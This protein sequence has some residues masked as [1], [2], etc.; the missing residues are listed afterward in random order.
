MHVPFEVNLARRLLKVN[1]LTPAVEVM[2]LIRKYADVEISYIPLDVDAVCLNLKRRGMRPSVIINSGRGHKRLRFTVAHELGHVLIP[3]HRGSIVDDVSGNES[4]NSEYFQIE[5]EAN[6]FAS[7]LLMPQ[8]WVQDRVRLIQSPVA[9]VSEVSDAADVSIQAAVF[10]TL[11]LLPKGFVFAE[12]NNDSCVVRSGRSPGTIA[13]APER[14]DIVDPGAE[15]PYAEARWPLATSGGFY[16]WWKL[17]SAIVP[18]LKVTS[19]WR[20][21]LNEILQDLGFQDASLKKAYSSVSAT[22]AN[23]NGAGRSSAD[24]V[25]ASI[26]QRFSSKAKHDAL[27]SRLMEHSKIGEY[28]IA[29]AYSFKK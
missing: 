17:P 25:H 5:S 8:D 18:T 14:D 29:R 6:R 9:L 11:A 24:E 15:F 26:I 2:G 4:M 22:A 16:W 10:R 12:V 3:W 19:D 13:N 20:S 7:E 21:I 28:F 27:Y 1:K 23:A